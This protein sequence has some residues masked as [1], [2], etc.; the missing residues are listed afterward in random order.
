MNERPFTA[1]V[2]AIADAK[3]PMNYAAAR[4]AIQQC[5]QIDECKDW[6]DKAA[7]LASYAKQ[8][9]DEQ[10]LKQCMRIKARATYRCGELLNEIESA[11]GTRTDQLS[12]GAPTKLTRKAAAEEAGLSKDRAVTAIRVA[13]VPKDSFE[14]QVESDNPP[15]VTELASQGMR[16][17]QESEEA[18]A[19]RQRKVATINLSRL[20]FMLHPRGGEPER[21]AERGFGMAEP[22]F[23]PS[24]ATAPFN[25]ETLE[26][27][28]KVMAVLTERWR[29]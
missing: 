23:W 4:K 17:R 8:A 3:L 28:A 7:A 12:G 11:Q 18:E 14:R 20:V 25:H 15:T 19:E 13:N 29:E 9:D 1:A 5:A 6:A 2:P 22:R 27:C 10:L 24:D 16:K 26:A 21:W